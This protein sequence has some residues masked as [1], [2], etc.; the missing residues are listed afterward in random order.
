VRGDE[1]EAMI[2]QRALLQYDA[3][4]GACQSSSTTES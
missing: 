2:Q 1:Y 4:Q 3:Q